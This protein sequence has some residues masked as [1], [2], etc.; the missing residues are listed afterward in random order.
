MVGLDCVSTQRPIVLVLAALALLPK[1]V[2]VDPCCSPVSSAGTASGLPV[3]M[4]PGYRKRPV[5]QF[6]WPVTVLAMWGADPQ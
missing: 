5:Q 3:D 1:V 4:S 6:M 2:T